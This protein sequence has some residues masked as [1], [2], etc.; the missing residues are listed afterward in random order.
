MDLGEEA[1]KMKLST[2]FSDLAL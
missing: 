1:V 2:V